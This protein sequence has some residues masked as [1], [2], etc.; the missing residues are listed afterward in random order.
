MIFILAALITFTVGW[1]IKYKRVTLFLKGYN[2]MKKEKMALYDTEKLYK[3][4]GN[5]YFSISVL[6]LI[7]G[8]IVNVTDIPDQKVIYVGDTIIVLYSLICYF[9]ILKKSKI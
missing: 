1:L 3:N 7:M 8:F 4:S 9:I 5:F 2:A 6:F